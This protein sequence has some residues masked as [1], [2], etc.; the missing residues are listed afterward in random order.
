MNRNPAYFNSNWNKDFI[1]I[2]VRKLGEAIIDD[3]RKNP[4]A[5]IKS[6]AN[7]LGVPKEIVVDPVNTLMYNGIINEH[8]DG[9]RI[10]ESDNA[11]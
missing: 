6:I 2:Q 3:I 11:V 10:I 9:Y 8:N 4:G 7:R 1:R 5:N